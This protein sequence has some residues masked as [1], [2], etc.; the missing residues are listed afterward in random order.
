MKKIIFTLVILISIFINSFALAQC[1]I[2]KHKKI[3]FRWLLKEYAC[4]IIGSQLA[5]KNNTQNDYDID[6]LGK[7]IYKKVIKSNLYYIEYVNFI[8]ENPSL[9]AIYTE[10]NKLIQKKIKYDAL[11]KGKVDLIKPA[12]IGRNANYKLTFNDNVLHGFSPPP[13]Q[14]DNLFF[15]NKEDLSASALTTAQE[16]ACAI[17]RDADNS[18][19]DIDSLQKYG[20]SI[21][22]RLETLLTGNDGSLDFEGVI[23]LLKLYCEL[24]VALAKPS[25]FLV[26]FDQ[27]H[28]SNTKY[29]ELA[30]KIYENVVLSKYKAFI[31]LEIIYVY[32][33]NYPEANNKKALE[34]ALK[35][36][37]DLYNSVDIETKVN[38]LY[39]IAYNACRCAA[40]PHGLGPDT[41]PKYYQICLDHYTAMLDILKPML[42]SRTL[43]QEKIKEFIIKAF[44][45]ISNAPCAGLVTL[46]ALFKNFPEAIKSLDIVI[47]MTSPGEDVHDGAVKYRELL[48]SYIKPI[49]ISNI[50]FLR[51]NGQEVKWGEIL[52]GGEKYI[53]RAITK[54]PCVEEFIELKYYSDFTMLIP[55]PIKLVKISSQNNT[56]F[57]NEIIV[58]NTVIGGSP[59]NKTTF[60]TFDFIANG[61]DS[62]FKDSDAFEEESAKIGNVKKGCSRDLSSG[63]V[64]SFDFNNPILPTTKDIIKS[65]GVEYL[66]ITYNDGTKFMVPFSNQANVLYF[67]SHGWHDTGKIL[68]NSTYNE[69]DGQM[70]PSEIDKNWRC[71][72]NQVIFAG[73]SVLDMKTPEDNDVLKPEE[74]PGFKWKTTG[75]Q[76]FLGY[77]KK[78]PKDKQDNDVTTEIIKRYFK[79]FESNKNRCEDWMKANNIR[80]GYIFTVHIGGNACAI[81][82]N[83]K[84]Y[85]YF[86][87]NTSLGHSNYDWKKINY[88]Y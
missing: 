12:M 17:W 51:S 71:G 11:D 86:V 60:M 73:C 58:D 34:F 76:I 64:A 39:L 25:S 80:R 28:F 4:K 81:E 48:L 3:C 8:N 56:V 37:N 13:I 16:T 43:S 75:P 32:Q 46:Y 72:L 42:N 29:T 67:S 84:E 77:R 55:K 35:A 44:Y 47:N 87:R 31:I 14:E 22:T 70:A 45:D 62:S 61:E 27:I 40:P 38:F 54:Q 10:L 59:E 78:A 74:Y 65:A 36:K 24:K 52:R 9:A 50:K 66:R 20:P 1:E 7:S 69:T 33:N 41:D 23:E 49:E 57:E 30:L 5:A 19:S 26:P 79:N 53:V 83:K 82:T 68:I 15:E 18:I 88:L 63:C 6:G 2:P 85:Y 21:I